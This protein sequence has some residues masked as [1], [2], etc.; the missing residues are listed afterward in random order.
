MILW[1]ALLAAF[2]VALCNGI[3][4]VLQKLSADKQKTVFSLRFKLLFLLIKDWPYLI[5]IILDIAAWIFTLIAVHNLPLFIVQPI[6]AFGV[7]ITV[8]VEH[9]VFRLKFKLQILL[10]IGLTIIGLLL[11]AI[12]AQPQVVIQVSS[13]VRLSILIAPIILVIIGAFFARRKD[14][15][16]TIILAAISGLAFGGTAI[17]GRILNFSLPY[18]HILYNQMFIA[19]IAYGIIG[20]LLFTMALQRHQASTINAVMITF[21][22]TAP[23]I[24][25]LLFFGD[26]PK[27]NLWFLVIIGLVIALSGTLMIAIKGLKPS[28]NIN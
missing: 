3:A 18:W 8:I 7:V 24:I 20:L 25:G 16:A 19:I 14:K 21:E 26:K 11:L 4:A 22:T 10:A 1:L 12:A 13:L 23:I 6:I 5:G 17:A 28:N 2:G 27:N 9:Y 15:S